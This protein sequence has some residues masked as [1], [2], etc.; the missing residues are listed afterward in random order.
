MSK[1]KKCLLVI[2]SILVV[3]LLLVGIFQVVS[4]AGPEVKYFMV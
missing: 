4:N 1:L 2:L 3:A